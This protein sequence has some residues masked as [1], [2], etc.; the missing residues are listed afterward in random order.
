MKEKVMEFLKGLTAKQIIIGI[1]LAAVI[2][3][4]MRLNSFIYYIH[5]Q[6]L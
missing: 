3:Y 2:I 1:A 6:H 4:I 5:Y